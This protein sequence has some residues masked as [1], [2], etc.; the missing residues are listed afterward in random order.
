[1]G[2]QNAGAGVAR[3]ALNGWRMPDLAPAALAATVAVQL[4][5]VAMVLLGVH[6][7]LGT[8][9]LFAFTGS[10]TLLGHRFWTMRGIASRNRSPPRW[11]TW[12]L[13]AV[14]F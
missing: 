5:A 8:L 10:A 7:R 4:G 6:A 14:S 13:W 12:R 11:D 9:I 1:M 3:H 2:S